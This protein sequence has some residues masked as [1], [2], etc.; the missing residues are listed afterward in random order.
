MIADSD[1]PIVPESL[2]LLMPPRSASASLALLAAE[3]GLGFDRGP[4]SCV[5]AAERTHP[6]RMPGMPSNARDPHAW[7][8]GVRVRA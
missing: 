8:L 5:I 7:E 3:L 4:R 1:E 2:D 6:A